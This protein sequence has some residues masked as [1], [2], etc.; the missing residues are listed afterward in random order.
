MNRK[1]LSLIA[2]LVL[3]CVFAISAVVAAEEAAPKA[4]APTSTSAPTTMPAK[5][6]TK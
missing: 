1:A 4:K 5:A 6:E 2:G 3:V